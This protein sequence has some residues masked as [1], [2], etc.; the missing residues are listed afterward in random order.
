M[1]VMKKSIIIL[2]THGAPPRDFPRQEMAEFFTLHSQVE[3]GKTLEPGALE[4]YQYLENRMREWPRTEQ[5][6][7]F[8][9]ASVALAAE[10]ERQTG[11]KAM[12]GFNEFCAP[13]IS[14]AI[15]DAAGQGGDNIT[16]VTPMLTRG[17]NH[18]EIEIAGIVKQAE[19]KHPGTRIVYAWPFETADTA[20]FLAKQVKRF[21][22]PS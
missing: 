6:D 18:A 9:A 16:V 14:R 8:Y 21:N 20:G 7:P 17:G 15:D 11:I 4:R 22:L 2:A 13:D 5:N 3:A 10:L 19:K 1:S 12:V